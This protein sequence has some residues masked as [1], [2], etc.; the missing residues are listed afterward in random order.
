[1]VNGFLIC[2]WSFSLCKYDLHA[3]HRWSALCISDHGLKFHEIEI[4]TKFHSNFVK[5]WMSKSEFQLLHR[6][7]YRN[8]LFWYQN[9]DSVIRILISVPDFCI[10]VEVHRILHWNTSKFLFQLLIRILILTFK[11][12]ILITFDKF[13]QSFHWKSKLVLVE[14]LIILFQELLAGQCMSAMYSL[15]EVFISDYCVVIYN[16]E[17][18]EKILLC[19]DTSIFTHH[20]NNIN[21]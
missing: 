2:R 16:Y 15:D 5:T 18:I 20:T 12:E 4:L 7:Q 3:T 6:F 11:I 8:F 21:Y 10:N 14:T 9:F 13:D 1:M 17:R 19:H